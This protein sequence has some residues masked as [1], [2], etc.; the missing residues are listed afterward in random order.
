MLHN[1]HQLIQI[2]TDRNI[3]NVLLLVLPIIGLFL[4]VLY[5][6]IFHKNGLKK[7]ISPILY[8]INNKSAH[9]DRS[10]TYGHIFSSALTI[11]FGGSAGF[12]APIVATGSAI[13]SNIARYFK[14]TNEDR[15]LLLASGAAAGISAIFNAPI[16]GVLFAIEVLLVGISVSAFIPLL[17]SSATGAIVSK[18]LFQE[19]LF[20]LITND[21]EL[22]AIPIYILLG[23]IAGLYSVFIIRQSIQVNKLFSK[24]KNKWFRAGIGGI[25]LSTLI[26]IFPSLYGEGYFSI[27]SIFNNEN[28]HILN[29]TLFSSNDIFLFA[30]IIAI[31]LFK[32]YATSITISAGGNGGIFAP[33]LFMGG[34]LGFLIASALAKFG[35][36][37]LNII[38]FTVAGMA[39]V[40]AG[41]IKIPLTSVFLIA[42]ITGGYALFVPLMIV[43]ATS[44]FI[45]SYFENKSIYTKELERQA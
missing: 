29:K 2:V 45:S 11:G 10:H 15:A 33:S 22:K 23:S 28:L 42:E 20:V 16:A 17:I 39:G 44:F 43:S 34:F 37:E 27:Q 26:F 1:V 8:A 13:G 19:K 31:L 25:I 41:V 30:S 7:G 24:F 9:I 18:I 32:P 35:L 12:E 3:F 21:W 5:L 6:S 40:L 38:N 36:M 14:F 4:T